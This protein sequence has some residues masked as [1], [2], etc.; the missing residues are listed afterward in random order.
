MPSPATSGCVTHVFVDGHQELEVARLQLILRRIERALGRAI[1]PAER[2]LVGNALL[3]HALAHTR[4]AMTRDGM[5]SGAIARR[6][7]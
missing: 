5:T 1:S 2:D 6:E 4:A 7:P 3:D